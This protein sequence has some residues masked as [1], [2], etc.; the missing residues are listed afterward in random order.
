ML[1]SKCLFS[2]SGIQRANRIECRDAEVERPG[3]MERKAEMGG[4]EKMVM[5]E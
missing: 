2:V 1:Y 5:R 4:S 3:E